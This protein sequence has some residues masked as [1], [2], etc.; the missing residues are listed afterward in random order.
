M[1]TCIQ[2][3]CREELVRSE[4]QLWTRCEVSG[5]KWGSQ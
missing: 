2:V 1:A 5:D 4:Q 3:S